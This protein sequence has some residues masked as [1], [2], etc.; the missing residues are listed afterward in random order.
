M[1]SPL[2]SPALLVNSGTNCLERPG[3]R[4][5]RALAGTWEQPFLHLTGVD[6]GPA[7][8][9]LNPPGHLSARRPLLAAAAA[10]PRPARYINTNEDDAGPASAPRC[11]HHTQAK[12]GQ[13]MAA[14]LITSFP[15][16]QQRHDCGFPHGPSPV[17]HGPSVKSP[18]RTRGSVFWSQ[19]QA[20]DGSAHS[21]HFSVWA[22]RLP[23]F[24][25]G[26]S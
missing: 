25:L 10:T 18:R 26:E 14:P 17:V 1:K 7:Q 16:V 4:Q 15:D 23:T 8:G 3:Q 12:Q 20:W 13:D 19:S 9:R 2:A 24:Q 5:L 6:S 22:P 11:Q 21:L